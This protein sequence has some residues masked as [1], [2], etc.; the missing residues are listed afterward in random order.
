V[1]GLTRSKIETALDVLFHG[2]FSWPPG[3]SA[4]ATLFKHR[5]RRHARRMIMGRWPPPLP[6]AEGRPIV[7][8]KLAD[9][10]AS[11]RVTEFVNVE[12][13]RRRLDELPGPEEVRA[14]TIAAAERG[15][16]PVPDDPGHMAALRLAMI[17]AEHE[18][19]VGLSDEPGGDGC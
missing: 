13:L 18:G 16:Q 2:G 10:A 5:F 3:V 4:G 14:E 9:L 11:S 1:T 17:L 19:L 12:A 6:L 15:E 7:L 8:E